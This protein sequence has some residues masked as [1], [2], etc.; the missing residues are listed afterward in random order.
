MKKLLSMLLVLMLILCTVCAGAE[1]ITLPGNQS[2]DTS[3]KTLIVSG[4]SVTLTDEASGEDTLCTATP[5]KPGTTLVQ[6]MAYASTRTWGPMNVLFCR[7]DVDDQL[8]ITATMI[9]TEDD[10]APAD[11]AALP[12]YVYPGEDAVTAAVCDYMVACGENWLATADVTIPAPIILRV[13][14][15]DD[16]HAVVYGNFWCHSYRAVDCLLVTASGVENPGV[17]KL[18]RTD[19]T[20][21]VTEA[22]F[23]ADGEDYA[24]SIERIANGDQALVDAYFGSGDLLDS[25]KL[26]F[27]RDYVAANDLPFL[28]YYDF[29]WPAVALFAE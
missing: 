15:P 6:F 26:T 10:E 3:W 8:Q 20:W 5:V 12:A 11:A 16:D 14:Y 4:D 21:A 19:D 23:A 7:F 17:M 1:S 29:Y 18:T 9:D 13:D 24:P 28:A 27:I 25:V 2:N 22:E